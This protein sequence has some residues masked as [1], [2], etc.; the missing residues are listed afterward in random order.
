MPLL[1]QLVLRDASLRARGVA[2]AGIAVGN[3]CV[4][5]GVEG[6]CGLDSLDIFVSTLERLAPGVSRAAIATAR[7]TEYV[8]PC[9]PIALRLPGRLTV[10]TTGPR[11]SGSRAPH[12]SGSGS[13]PKFDG[14]VV[15]LISCRDC[16]WSDIC[17]VR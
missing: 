15:S 14:C 5:Y 7:Y 3:G 11:E 17:A 13:T 16:G 6:G 8:P 9:A 10:A 1:A 2:L 4:G 12:L